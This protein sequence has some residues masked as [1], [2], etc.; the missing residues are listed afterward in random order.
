ML[1]ARDRS[2]LSLSGFRPLV[3]LELKILVRVIALTLDIFLLE[4]VLVSHILSLFEELLDLTL[5]SD[6]LGELRDHASLAAF[7]LVDGNDGTHVFTFI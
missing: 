2:E 7:F 1:D 5:L 6:F 4:A 3:D